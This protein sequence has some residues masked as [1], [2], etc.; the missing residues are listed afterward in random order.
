M[1]ILFI[2]CK[3]RFLCVNSTYRDIIEYCKKISK[4]DIT[5]IYTNIKYSVE[6][7]NNLNPEVV[8]FFDIDNL[9]YG[10][11]FSFVFK[12][13]VY[14]VSLDLFW[15]K[16]CSQCPYIKLCKGILTFSKASKLLKS[17]QDFFPNKYIGSLQGRYINT[18][19]YKNYNRPKKYDILIYG[20]RSHINGK[21]YPSKIENHFADLEYVKNWE[22]HNKK[23]ISD[24]HV[25][26]PL[27]VKLEL[28]LMKNKHKYNLKILENKG[29]IKCK[30]VN[31]S[32]AK[33]INESHL[34][35]ASCSRADI[36]MDKYVEIA[37]SYSAILGNI[38]SDYHDLFKNNIVEVTEWMSDEEILSIIDKALKDK[39]KLWDMT[40][41][42]GDR[43]HKEYD[44]ESAK[45]NMDNVFDE[46][47][48]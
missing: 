42:L 8:I 45:N 47:F 28:L 5:I 30:I 41:R 37:G 7:F 12:K 23:K 17:Y 3:E 48:R 44:L 40:K 43:V 29:S 2:C 15:F 36:L 34:T 11:K 4:Y 22:K 20:S 38:P 32:L 9:R 35:L 13:P 1:K 18:D 26:Y 10:N 46:I 27:R 33:L 25:F 19:I 16:Q 39:K 21:L 6:T 14:L 24:C 31:D